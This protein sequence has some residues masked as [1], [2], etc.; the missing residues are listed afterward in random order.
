[1]GYRFDAGQHADVIEKLAKESLDHKHDPFE[2]NWMEKPTAKL[3][4]QWRHLSQE[5]RNAVATELVKK[6]K[7]H[8]PNTL[9]IPEL[10]TDKEGNVTAI[11]FT[12]SALD[13]SSGPHAIKLVP[14][15]VGIDIPRI[16][17]N[18]K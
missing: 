7:N 13:F 6:Y 9:P 16:K 11:N 10:E 15:A 18:K 1:M 4:E 8:L 5:D 3:V 14:N 12:A 17:P 2:T